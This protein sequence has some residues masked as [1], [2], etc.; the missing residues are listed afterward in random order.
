MYGYGALEK[1]FHNKYIVGEEDFDFDDGMENKSVFAPNRHYVLNIKA[2]LVSIFLPWILFIVLH[3]LMVFKTHYT[4]PKVVWFVLFVGLGTSSGTAMLAKAKEQDPLGA[5]PMW[6]RYHSVAF[7]FA[8][9]WAV[10]GGSYVFWNY[11]ERFYDFQNLNVYNNINPAKESG[12]ML[13]DAGRV[14][15]TQGTRVATEFSMGF[16]HH[17][18]YCVAPI[19]KGNERLPTYDFWTVGKN[20]CDHPPSRF[21]CGEALRTNARSAIRQMNEEDR[22]FYRLAVQQAEAAYGFK[23]VHPVF[24][25][26]DQDPVGVVNS[27]HFEQLRGFFGGAILFFCIN[28]FF[29]IVATIAFTKI[30]RFS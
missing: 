5:E 13:M 6:Y 16:K 23:A 20:C 29:V 30:G 1:S 28:L 19:V 3:G 12:Q 2:I 17:D 7:I 10:V 15:W 26:Y 14:Y 18:V 21:Q 11:S 4:Y 22:P 27:L 24:F 8:T 9:F 25:H